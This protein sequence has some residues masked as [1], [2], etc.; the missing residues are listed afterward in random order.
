MSNAMPD[1]AAGAG[2]AG[3]IAALQH[4]LLELRGQVDAILA[5]LGGQP[6]SPP[7]AA[8]ATA[9]QP[10]PNVSRSEACGVSSGGGR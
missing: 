9:M 10:R 4:R 8:C 6:V 7:A 2:L 3:S 1:T 5:L